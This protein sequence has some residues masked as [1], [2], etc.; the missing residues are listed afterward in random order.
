MLDGVIFV[1]RTSDALDLDLL[2][3]LTQSEPAY[4]TWH[5]EMADDDQFSSGFG[6]SYDRIEDDVLYIK[7]DDDIVSC[8]P[9]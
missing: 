2:Y 9:I 7:I 1:E 6:N 5:I 4:E 8:Q 3:R